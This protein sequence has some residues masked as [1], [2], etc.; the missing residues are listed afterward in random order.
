MDLQILEKALKL[1]WQYEYKW[2]R[3]QQDN[4]DQK[5]NFIYDTRTF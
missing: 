2:G 5:T 1:M 4:W 3:K